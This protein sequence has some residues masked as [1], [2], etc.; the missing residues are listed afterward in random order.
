MM[1]ELIYVI[2]STL[3]PFARKLVVSIL[4]EDIVHFCQMEKLGPSSTLRSIAYGVFGICSWFIRNFGLPRLS[5]YKRAPD[6]PNKS[7]SICA[8]R[9]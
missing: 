4:D 6:A 3:K 5:P 8:P 1:N 9:T 2:P 7:V